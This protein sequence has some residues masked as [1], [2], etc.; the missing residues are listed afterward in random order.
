M[1]AAHSY[2]AQALF[3]AYPCLD[4]ELQLEQRPPEGWNLARRFNAG[5]LALLA[6]LNR[7]DMRHL[8]L[9]PVLAIP[10]NWDL[11]DWTYGPFSPDEARLRHERKLLI[12]DLELQAF[13]AYEYGVLTRWGPI[14]SGAAAHPTPSGLFHLNWKSKGR[15]STVN[16]QWFMPHYFNFDNANGLSLHAYAMP[17]RPA[18]HACIRMLETDAMWLQEWGEAWTLQGGA[19]L[20]LGTR[21]W[22]TGRYRFDAEPPWLAPVVTRAD[23]PAPPDR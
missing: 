7:A 4:P 16:P 1:K 2:L 20:R 14:S 17:G 10:R 13:A 15:H 11:P 23:I 8:N 3:L 6:K 19:I 5:Q 22:I 12:A 18:S 21:L 9:L